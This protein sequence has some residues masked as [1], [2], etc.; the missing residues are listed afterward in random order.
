MA[1]FFSRTEELKRIVGKGHLVGIFAVDG[2]PR[3]VPLEV[4]FWRSG[5]LAGVHIQNWTTPGTG[6]NAV[7]NSLE[8]S[9]QASLEDIA[10]TL[11][12]EGPQ[13]GMI[14]HTER[15]KREFMPR[16][17]RVTGEYADSS[18]RFVTDDGQLIY[19][20][21]DEHYGQAPQ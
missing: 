10:K 1:D 16:A 3:S 19:E 9:Y 5:P 15:M 7:Q 12:A 4:G 18:A 17:P 11:L 2:G 13:E 14:R 8:A 6:A 20:R 21:F